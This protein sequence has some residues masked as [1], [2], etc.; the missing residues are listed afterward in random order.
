MNIKLVVAVVIVGVF[1]ILCSLLKRLSDS[2]SMKRKYREAEGKIRRRIKPLF[3]EM[4]GERRYLVSEYE[5]CI[6]MTKDKDVKAW[7]R[8]LLAQFYHNNPDR[9][10]DY[11]DK[12]IECYTEITKEF[13]DYPFHEESLFRLGNLLFFEKFDQEKVCNVYQKLLK[14]ETPPI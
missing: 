13:Y 7:G 6:R 14:Q 11:L 4:E 8:W 2:L 3:K 9:E 10:K 12:A 1:A 5:E